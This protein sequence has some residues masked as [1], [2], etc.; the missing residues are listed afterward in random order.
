MNI[1]KVLTSPLLYILIL[2]VGGGYWF[3]NYLSMK[4]NTLSVSGYA[5]TT[6]ENQ[7]A[8]FSA[9]V[10]TVDDKK[11]VAVKEVNNKVD[12]LINAV[13]LFGIPA[14]ELK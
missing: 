2:V 9:G 8:S 5:D 3:T 11:E 7:V 10:S 4:N 1:N 13:K 12:S 14:F 6:V